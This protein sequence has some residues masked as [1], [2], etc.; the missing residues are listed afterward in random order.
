MAR[1]RKKHNAPKGSSR[2]KGDI[3]EK[4]IADMHDMPG[5]KIERNVFLPAIDKSGRTREIDVLITSEVAGFPVRIAIECKNEKEP[6]GIAKIGEF[7]D[8]LNDIGLPVQLGVFVSTSR[9]ES[10]AIERSKSVGI[11]TLLLQ[12]TSKEL[13]E[14]VK[15]AYQSKIYLQLTITN[16]QISNDIPGPAGAG[17]VLFFRD[18]SGKVSGSVA[19]LAWKEWISGKLSSQI[20]NHEVSLSL[21]SDWRQIVKGVVA[22]VSEIK[23][24][25]QVAGYAI[26]FQGTVSQYNLLNAA[27]KNTEKSQTMVRF[28]PPSGKY[29]TVYFKS[30]ED[31]ASFK[32]ETKGIGV[33][34]GRF[35]LPRIV[36][37]A[38]YWP[39][40][41]KAIQKLNEKLFDSLRKGEEFDL[42]KISLIDIEGEDLSTIWEPIIEDHPM[43]SKKS[44]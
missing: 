23:I 24:S 20:G 21:P 16:I 39:P 22:K 11:R 17:E 4:I 40:S 2:E 28:T 25:Y 32:K 44:S 10:G 19:D 30:E 12:D 36:W 29:P 3:L 7:I 13:P 35:R 33:I 27:D 41:K 37:Y 8:K 9:Y 42:N 15:T 6:T 14:A 18:E 34:I 5:L 26:S 38:I 43:L 31:L 1:T